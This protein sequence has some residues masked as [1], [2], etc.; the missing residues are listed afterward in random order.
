MVLLCL[1]CRC[2]FLLCV[3]L[4]KLP[5]VDTLCDTMGAV[6]AIVQDAAHFMRMNACV[7][8][9]SVSVSLSLA[10]RQGEISLA[11]LDW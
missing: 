1:W 6:R 11:G 5:A 7:L 8:V 10:P 4:C 9:S 3:R 2:N